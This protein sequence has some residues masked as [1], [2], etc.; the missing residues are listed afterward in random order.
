[1]C[2]LVNGDV[3]L[4]RLSLSNG[5]I[6]SIESTECKVLYTHKDEVT[7]IHFNQTGSKIVSCSLDRF[8]SV[9][10]VDTGMILFKKEHPNCLICLSWCFDNEFIYTGDNAGYIY[11][12]NMIPGELNCTRNAFN[13]PVTSITSKWC[14]DLKECQIIV[15][16]VDKMEYLIKAF[17]NK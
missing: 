3:V 9:C 16:G 13:G 7:A 4:W 2:G 11:A 12:W 8:L 10:D 6:N 5:N 14:A 17:T 1:M 15:A